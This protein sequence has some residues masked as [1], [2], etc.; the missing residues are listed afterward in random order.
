MV[1]YANSDEA[2]IARLNALALLSE[3]DLVSIQT[4]T[5]AYR[6]NESEENR[7]RNTQVYPAYLRSVVLRRNT[8]LTQPG[9]PDIGGQT[10]REQSQKIDLWRDRIPANG[11]QIFTLEV[12]PQP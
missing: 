5:R 2:A 4:G 9:R 8:D 12:R 7:R 10:W 11:D 1:V 6:R 3:D